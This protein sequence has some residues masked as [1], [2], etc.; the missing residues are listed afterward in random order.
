MARHVLPPAGTSAVG[1]VHTCPSVHWVSSTQRQKPAT[2]EP[3]QPSSSSQRTPGWIGSISGHV[4]AQL[5]FDPIRISVLSSLSGS[6][7]MAFSYQ[8]HEVRAAD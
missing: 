8:V 6:A 4:T 5:V 1:A 2:H 3:G 7:T